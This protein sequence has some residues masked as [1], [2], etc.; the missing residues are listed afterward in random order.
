MI[1]SG[2]VSLK[3]TLVGLLIVR[4]G[5]VV[6]ESSNG[7]AAAIGS[8][9][10]YKICAVSGGLDLA[11][12]VS[13]NTRSLFRSAIEDVEL[14]REY[15][16]E[17]ALNGGLVGGL[18]NLDSMAATLDWRA[19]GMSSGDNTNTAGLGFCDDREDRRVERF[20]SESSNKPFVGTKAVDM[21][22]VDTASNIFPWIVDRRSVPTKWWVNHTNGR[23][24]LDSESADNSTDDS[25][26]DSEN[27]FQK[28]YTAA[29]IGTHGE[30][31]LYYPPLRVYGHPLG[32]GDVLSGQYDSH[33][34]E[35]VRP[36]LPM[37]NPERYVLG[38][39]IIRMCRAPDLYFCYCLSNQTK[40]KFLLYQA[41]PRLGC[42]WPQSDHRPS[43]GLPHGLVPG[44]PVSRHLLGQ[45]WSRY[46]RFSRVV[47]S[48]CSTRPVGSRKF[49]NVGRFRL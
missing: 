26:N 9:K 11:R 44:I 40:K 35:F 8:G 18:S 3:A 42:S 45:H 43:A 32:F 30:A 4:L 7:Y 23:T 20:V 49:R 22:L 2:P 24:L 37:N 14:I 48:G 28:L 46:C 6:G 13:S 39:T 27:Q 47:Q 12:L 1:Q 33:D 19:R 25:T 31:W 36:N 10:A 15:I 21:A 38:K 29:W 34:E 41:V 16:S 5:S 17:A